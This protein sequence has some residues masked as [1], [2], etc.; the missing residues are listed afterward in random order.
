MIN[1]VQTC[2]NESRKN[3]I[4][5]L[6]DLEP[7]GIQKNTGVSKKMLF[8][9]TLDNGKLLN[10]LGKNGNWHPLKIHFDYSN[11]NSIYESNTSSYD[12]I[13]KMLMPTVRDY[14]NDTLMVR[15]DSGVT[16]TNEGGECAEAY[17]SPDIR[18]ELVD[19]D[20]I[21][22]ITTE[23]EGKDTIASASP[24]QIHAVSG[25]PVVGR[26]NFNLKMID[27]NFDL[28]F[29][30][31]GTIYHEITHVLGFEP[32][33]FKYFL[34]PNMSRYKK[35][36]VLTTR[37][38]GGKSQTMIQTPKVVEF[39]RKHFD[40]DSLPGAAVEDA[41]GEGS[42]GA[43]WEKVYFGGE[44]MV[45]N[46]VIN[47]VISGL[48]I[49]LLEDSGWY[50]FR[51]GER[52]DTQS[53][54][55]KVVS[56]EPY[57]WLK[58]YGC[59]V[60]VENCPKSS[61]SCTKT[62]TAG[63]SYDDTF[64]ATCNSSEFTAVKLLKKNPVE[65]CSY[66]VGNDMGLDDCRIENN[67]DE[68][69]DMLYE[70]HGFN[71]RCFNSNVERKDTGDY[72][73]G[74]ICLQPKCERQGSSITLKFQ[75]GVK[76]YTCSKSNEKIAVNDANIKGN[77]SCPANMERF[78]DRYLNKCPNDCNM[79]GRCMSDGQCLCY[80]GFSGVSCGG[81]QTSTVVLKNGVMISKT[82]SHGCTN[83]C[84]NGTCM[85]DIGYCM[86]DTGYKSLDC[87]VEDDGFTGV[88][89]SVVDEVASKNAVVVKA[90]K[91]TK[92]GFTNINHPPK[93]K[94]VRIFL[95][96]FSHLKINIGEENTSHQ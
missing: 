21:L 31:F 56:T 67:A 40:C 32:D 57:Y 3:Y 12:F 24:C 8:E 25:R 95:P 66:Y 20:L 34:K 28:F 77:I 48:T 83:G 68:D 64:E 37:K 63:C 35:E 90:I 47:P 30:Q 2:S 11:L 36:E 72:K 17:G 46:S 86:C 45:S 55:G 73:D 10:D 88:D 91:S 92:S 50:K 85:D 54:D 79:R 23:S 33:Q 29:D 43:H 65:T 78:C 42:A 80:S 27:N 51:K 58:G 89:T 18:N 38:I 53:N 71:R 5:N 1:K 93:S 49:A 74:T 22:V 14:V 26:V 70:T 52:Q 39:V 16:F 75:Y 13:T 69:K 41:G 60:Y 59:G 44:Y 87:S 4:R 62:G 61:N 6:I 96:F 76:W 19:A 15:E 94:P 84:K 9:R 81:N 7:V 82:V